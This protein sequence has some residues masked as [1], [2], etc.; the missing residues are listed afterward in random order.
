MQHKNPLRPV[1]DG[2]F[3]LLGPSPTL[4]ELATEG[5]GGSHAPRH[6]CVDHHVY[7]GADGAWHLWGCIRKTPVGRILYRWEGRD[8]AQGPWRQ[9][10]EIVRADRLAGESL[11]DWHGE[12]WIQSP[13]VVR[14][15]GTFFMFYGGHGTGIEAGGSPVP[16]AD[17][18]MDCQMCL[19]TSPDGRTWTRHR[20]EDGSSRL[21]LGPGETRDP[22]LIRIDGRWRMYC[23]GYHDDDPCQA[24]IYTRSS[25]DLIHWSDWQL[26]HQ[27][28]RYGPGRWGTE[29]PHVV[30]RQ[31]TYY[32]FRTEN[33]AQA[34]THVFRSENPLDFG[35]GDARAHYIGRIAVAAPEIVVDRRGNEYITSNHD[36]E[37]G[38]RI[39]RLRWEEDRP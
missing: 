4:S 33:Y 29:C 37:A 14:D 3:W 13:F 17:P 16:H 5:S 25:A 28:P 26:V 2:D 31:G 23:A 15:G 19:M 18:R 39:S 12:E 11:D 32:L 30:Y 20:N 35:I 36:L 22:C 9:T 1:L 34:I 21:F 24:G 38:T 8:P 6:E 7:Q 27:D 10:G